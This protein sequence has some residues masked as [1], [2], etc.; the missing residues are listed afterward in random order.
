[1]E[2]RIELSPDTLVQRV[3]WRF[4]T[5]EPDEEAGGW[6]TFPPA[7]EGE[8]PPPLLPVESM[9]WRTRREALTIRRAHWFEEWIQAPGDSVPFLPRRDGAGG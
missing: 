3:A 8:E 7:R 9:T 1:M 6:A 4:L 2:G 5:P